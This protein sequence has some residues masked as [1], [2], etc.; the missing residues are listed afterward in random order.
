MEKLFLFRNWLQ[1]ILMTFFVNIGPNLASKINST[2]KE[3]HEY[4]KDPIQKVFSYL[5]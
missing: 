2:G 4:L 1:M 5:Q 3:Y